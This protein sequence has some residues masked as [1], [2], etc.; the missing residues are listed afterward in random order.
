MH[1]LTASGPSSNNYLTGNLDIGRIQANVAK[2][3]GLPNNHQQ[4]LPKY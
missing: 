3:A 2:H 4:H 1:S